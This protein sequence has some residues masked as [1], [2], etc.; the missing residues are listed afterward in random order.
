[1][2]TDWN[3]SDP[4]CQR[5]AGVLVVEDQDRQSAHLIATLRAA[6]VEP[7]L[8]RTGYE[9]IKLAS[10]HRPALIFMD[11]LLPGMHGFEVARFVRSIDPAYV[12]HIVLTTAIYKNVKYQNEA[13]LKYGINEYLI[14]PVASEHIGRIL[15]HVGFLTALPA[16]AVA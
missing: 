2:S 9:A 8:A 12:P 11:A 6:N 14:K 5:P 4:H 3:L 16:V 15:V 1:M 13:I 10:M 7:L